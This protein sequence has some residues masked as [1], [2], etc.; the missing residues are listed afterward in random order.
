MLKAIRNWYREITRPPDPA[1][2]PDWNAPLGDLIAAGAARFERQLADADQPDIDAFLRHER[3]A[4]ERPA[5]GPP[6][7]IAS[8]AACLV[9]ERVRAE[10]GGEWRE[11][12]L[13]GVALVG[14]GGIPGAAFAPL[15]L[16]EK[17]WE[18]G[19]G[20]SV[21]RFVESI[22]ARLEAERAFKASDDRRWTLRD[23]LGKMSGAKAGT[24]QQTATWFAQRFRQ[25]WFARHKAAL[26]LSLQGVREAEA[27]LRSQFFLLFLDDF[28]L[29]TMGF[30]LG[31]VTRGLFQGE[32][33]FDEALRREDA[34]RAALAW[35]ELPYY[36]V[37]KVFKMLTEQ[38]EDG[39][40][41]EYV[42][43]VPSARSELRKQAE[44]TE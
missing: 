15:R 1:D 11:H 35:P 40:F 39:A 42:R 22:P 8:D 24:E 23:A 34:T 13:L 19:D 2:K 29:A 31:E 36:P 26:P 28:E 25:R 30:F 4:A 27:Y 7:Q 3:A 43:L 17:R 16:V 41:D 21:A 18:I 9:G 37:G 33:T 5:D 44:E 12:H 32:W 10:H 38:P 20:L 14:V 6:R